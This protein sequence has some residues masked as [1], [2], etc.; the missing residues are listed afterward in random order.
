MKKLGAGLAVLGVFLMIAVG[1]NSSDDGGS[2]G[3][4]AGSNAQLSDGGES[5]VQLGMSEQEVRDIL[6]EPSRTMPSSWDEM[7][8]WSYVQADGKKT[9]VSFDNGR[10]IDVAS[11]SK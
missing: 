4:G 8:A 10:V 3:S 2:S 5:G 1:C 6:G 11:S 7:D 9:I